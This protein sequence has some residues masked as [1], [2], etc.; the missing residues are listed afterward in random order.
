MQ[1]RLGERGPPHI[2]LWR[3]WGPG[4]QNNPQT[5]L[6]SLRSDQVQDARALE[7][8]SLTEGR[9]AG[10]GN[11]RQMRLSPGIKALHWPV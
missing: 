7:G 6:A 9:R 3:T 4:P 11:L 2:S 1:G 8:R 5:K 10:R